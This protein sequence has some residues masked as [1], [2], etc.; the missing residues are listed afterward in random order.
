MK[1]E[2]DACINLSIYIFEHEKDFY[3]YDFYGGIVLELNE[4]V[5]SEIK[6]VLLGENKI[7]VTNKYV[8]ELL[9]SDI[10]F[11]K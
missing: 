11:K 10:F 1:L 9:L 3:L 4:E 6:K 5:Y 7:E 2:E 8:R